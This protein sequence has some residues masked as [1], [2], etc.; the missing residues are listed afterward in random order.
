MHAIH[1]ECRDAGPRVHTCCACHMAGQLAEMWSSMVTAGTSGAAGA[2][3]GRGPAAKAGISSVLH[4]HPKLMVLLH[5]LA[6]VLVYV[7]PKL[8]AGFIDTRPG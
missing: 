6:V 4:M 7:C 5:P 1:K 2:F 8:Q 3:S